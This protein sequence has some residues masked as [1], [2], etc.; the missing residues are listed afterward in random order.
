ME[1]SKRL[2]IVRKGITKPVT[3]VIPEQVV[4]EEIEVDTLQE[5]LK[6]VNLNEDQLRIAVKAYKDEKITQPSYNM[7]DVLKKVDLGR[8]KV[9]QILK[10]ETGPKLELTDSF[11][12]DALIASNK[13][14]CV[15]K[16]SNPKRYIVERI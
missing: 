1:E 6:E 3:T 5:F 16:L 11:V 4:T 15:T 13:W 2:N 14:K 12:V 8:E 9:E 7:E 10:N